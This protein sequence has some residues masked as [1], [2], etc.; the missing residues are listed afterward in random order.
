MDIFTHAL[1]PYLVGSILKLNKRELTALVLG[2][3]VPDLDFLFLGINYLYPSDLLLVHRG[4]THTLIF[5]FLTALVALYAV[6]RCHV[7]RIIQRFIGSD[8]FDLSKTWKA[9]ALVYA[10]VLSHLFLDYL[11]TRGVPL[12]YPLD[13]SRFSAE[14]FSSVEVVFAI[15]SLV[16]IAMLLR[17]GQ[18]RSAKVW[19]FAAFLV[20]IIAAGSI[21]M[22]GKEMSGMVLGVG[23]SKSYPE[24]DLFKW[25]ILED[26]GSRF[27]VYE[28]DLISG[29][30]RHKTAFPH[31]EV[32]QDA[33]G[34]REGL[35]AALK[36]ADGL[37]QV[38]LFRWRAYAVAINASLEDGVWHLEYF[39]PVI[40]AEQMHSMPFL[41]AATSSYSSVKVKVDADDAYKAAVI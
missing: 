9:L 29:N 25:S 37:P 36:A 23:S 21:R 38:E 8:N 28:Y 18:N 17:Y 14:V 13:A 10:G 24:A 12:F 34:S 16:I 30:T 32:S 31:L 19:L 40:R 26:N 2:G 22:E 5:G 7:K 3:I 11:T 27:D 20:V 41:K 1:I 33:S 4:I 6:S 39:D 35:G 15:T